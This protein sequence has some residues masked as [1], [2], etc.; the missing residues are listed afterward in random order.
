VKLVDA[1]V[2]IYA[3]NTSEPRHEEARTWLDS[4]LSSEETVAFAWVALLAFVRLTTREGLF[5]SPLPVDLA[6]AQVTEWTTAPPSVLLEPTPRHLGLLGG[7]M[8]AVG[9]AGNLVTDAHLAAL[10]LEHGAT[11]VT[12]DNDFD[13]FPGLRWS[14]PG[15]G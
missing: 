2:L 10:A 7:L 3:V 6:I 11:V 1:N 13:R 15:Q 8:E 4:A 14:R 12:Y 9:T 5:P